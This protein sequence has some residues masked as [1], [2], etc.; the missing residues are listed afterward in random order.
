MQNYTTV[1]LRRKVPGVVPRAP[2]PTNPE[3]MDRRERVVRG[4]RPPS[5]PRNSTK[6][7]GSEAVPHLEA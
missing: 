1:S 6:L 5:Q 2:G 7:P 3:G 4:I